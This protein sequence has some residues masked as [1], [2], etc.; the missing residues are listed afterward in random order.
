[1][2]T[3]EIFLVGGIGFAVVALAIWGWLK[4]R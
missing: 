1:M 3:I 4:K 2:G